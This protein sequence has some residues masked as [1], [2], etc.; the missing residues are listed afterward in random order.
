MTEPYG[1]AR[2]SAFSVTELLIVVTVLVILA[3]TLIVG[4]NQMYSRAIQVKCQ[5]R[6]EQIGHALMMHAN[7][8]HGRYPY[9]KSP[10]TG[11]MWYELLAESYLDDPTVIACPAAD[12]APAIR[13]SIEGTALTEEQIE[14]AHK[15]FFWLKSKQHQ[16]SGAIQNGDQPVSTSV[17]LMGLLSFGYT[18]RYPEEFAETVQLAVHYLCDVSQQ[19]SGKFPAWADRNVGTQGICMMALAAASISL[20]DPALRQKSYDGAVKALNWLDGITQPTTGCYSYSTGITSGSQRMSNATMTYQGIGACRLAGIPIP[21]NITTGM[22]NLL[23][24]NTG[25]IGQSGMGIGGMSKY[26]PAGASPTHQYGSVS[27]QWGQLGFPLVMRLMLGDS[28]GSAVVQNLVP[29][30]LFEPY[31]SSKYSD[32]YR[33]Y[34]MYHTT[35]G[36][37]L[38]GG[39]RWEQWL[40]R[41]PAYLTK[42]MVD[43]SADGD[44]NLRGYWP[45]STMASGNRSSHAWATG[46]TLMMLGYANPNN[47]LSEDYEPGSG[48]ACSYGYNSHLRRTPGAPASD[49]IMVMD[50]ANWLIVRN[51]SDL[52]ADENDD[53]SMVQARHSGHA[54]ALMADGRVKELEPDGVAPGMWT[55][56]HAD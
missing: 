3:A 33:R 41:Y 36:L 27:P 45:D 11:Q 48:G 47:W 32:G 52:S 28:T 35:L 43:V 31:S 24:D 53:P 4:A 13:G 30:Q 2:A 9:A 8:D 37:R 42:Q 44:G 14:T 29:K 7:K 6:L 38:A 19:S 15:A 26:W 20:E 51:R 49:T 1:R 54:N 23:D 22:T 18:D 12:E 16:T 34:K 17:A 56:Q 46:M 50:Y 40:D 39:S 5:H 25:Y 21:A 10:L 55:P